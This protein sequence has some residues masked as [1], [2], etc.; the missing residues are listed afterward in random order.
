[1]N[2]LGDR[3]HDQGEDVQPQAEQ[4]RQRLPVIVEDWA[5]FHTL[6][7]DLGLVLLAGAMVQVDRAGS[8]GCP[9]GTRTDPSSRLGVSHQRLA[10]ARA[11]CDGRASLMPAANDSEDRASETRTLIHTA[12]F[13]LRVLPPCL[14]LFLLPVLLRRLVRLVSEQDLPDLEDLRCLIVKPI[15][16]ALRA[17]L[18]ARAGAGAA[19]EDIHAEV[20]R[21]GKATKRALAVAVA[22]RRDQLGPYLAGA[23][24]VN[25]LVRLTGLDQARRAAIITTAADKAGKGEPVDGVRDQLRRSVR[26][27]KKAA[28]RPRGSESRPR[29]RTPSPRRRDVSGRWWN[30]SRS[31]TRELERWGW[32]LPGRPCPS[33]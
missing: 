23:C 14:R 15:S 24:S 25:E 13:L 17:T 1:M 16:V 31:W 27:A 8:D 29:D 6:W 33:R 9:A 26:A 7:C 3:T 32:Q 18:K 21:L 30:R 20:V 12:A 11:V 5:W 2:L 4:E 10:R 22:G 19:A 28:A